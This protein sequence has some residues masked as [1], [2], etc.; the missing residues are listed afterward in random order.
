MPNAYAYIYRINMLIIKIGQ[1]ICTNI[2]DS[3]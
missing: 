2:K 3:M 1:L